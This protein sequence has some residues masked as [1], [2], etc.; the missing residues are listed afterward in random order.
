MTSFKLARQETSP[1]FQFPKTE[2]VLANQLLKKQT[3]TK[4]K[5][6]QTNKKLQPESSQ[7]ETTPPSEGAHQLA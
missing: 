2:Q 4:N 3:T 7:S 6:K 5:N 1:K